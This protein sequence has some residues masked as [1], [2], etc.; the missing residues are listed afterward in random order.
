MVVGTP[1]R[2]QEIKAWLEQ[3]SQMEARGETLV[4]CQLAMSSKRQSFFK[5]V[6]FQSSSKEATFGAPGIATR[7]KDATRGS[8]PY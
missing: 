6:L 8:W 3:A 4:F 2:R 7:S 5:H 1:S